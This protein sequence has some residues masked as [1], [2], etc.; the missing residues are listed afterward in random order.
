MI[1]YINA[2]KVLCFRGSL[3]LG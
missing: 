1:K 3:P 2:H